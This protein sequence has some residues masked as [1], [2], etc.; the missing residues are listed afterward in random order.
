MTTTSIFSDDY[1]PTMTV[2]QAAELLGVSRSSG[3]RAAALGQLP[4]IRLGRRLLVPTAKL[5]A[6]L[7]S[8]GAGGVILPEDES[9]A[10]VQPPI[11]KHE[12]VERDSK[13]QLEG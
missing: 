8:V 3:Y 6:M 2:E 9:S 5:L 11:H 1:P 7:G 12:Q 13:S 10:S 4:T